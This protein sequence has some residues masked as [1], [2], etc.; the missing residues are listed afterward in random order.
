MATV[1]TPKSGE[2]GLWSGDYKT[3]TTWKFQMRNW[4]RRHS[5]LHM[6]NTLKTCENLDT[7]VPYETIEDEQKEISAKI[8]TDLALKTSDKALR[9]VMSVIEPDN[10]LEAWRLLCKR[11]E[12]GT[13]YKRSGLLQAILSFDFRGDFGDRLLQFEGMV[14]EFNRTSTREFD[15]MIQVATVTQGASGKLRESLMSRQFDT[16]GSLRVFIDEWMD[17]RRPYV[18][19]EQV[20]K[21]GGGDDP[22]EVDAFT[23][24]KGKGK[25]KGKY[26]DNFKGKGYSND[27]KGKSSGKGKN[28]SYNNEQHYG[29]G[30]KGKDGGKSK[31]KGKEYKAPFAGYCDHCG[32][33]GHKQSD[34]WMK[35]SGKPVNNVE[36]EASQAEQQPASSP[37][38]STPCNALNW[39]SAASSSMAAAASDHSWMMALT[40]EE[41]LVAA[42]SSGTEMTWALVDSGSAV[43]AGPRSFGEDVELETPQVRH[44]L[45]AV[46]GQKI[47]H[48]GSRSIP[49]NIQTSS[50][51]KTA[52]LQ[53]EIADVN[54]VVISVGSLRAKGSGCWFP[55]MDGKKYWVVSEDNEY[56]EVGS[57]PCITHGSSVA[58]MVEHGGVFWLPL[59]RD[60]PG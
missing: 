37:T 23:K 52:M 44:N 46:G 34:C 35:Q 27:N 29:N 19:S 49:C 53:T 13:G 51:Y 30:Y 17:I 22:M 41:N 9:I 8:M 1:T 60:V 40:V 10:G 6:S 57:G 7:E 45:T 33:W 55:P 59:H 18:L 50:G 58:P 3:W 12:G 31:S 15:E 16:Y 43:T 36:K 20:Q 47:K 14:A 4:L 54:K 21:H 48:H 42:V 38:S 2:P 24:G 39:A 28:K 26:H 11:G 25:N 56:I 32:K 5:P